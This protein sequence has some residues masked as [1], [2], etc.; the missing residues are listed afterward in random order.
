MIRSTLHGP[1]YFKGSGLWHDLILPNGG[2][3]DEDKFHTY[4]V[5]WSPG[6]I[7]FYAGDPANTFFVEEASEISNGGEWVFDGAFYLFMNLA[8][9]GYWPE[10]ADATTPNPAGVLVGYVRVHKVPVV[11]A[12]SI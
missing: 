8:V 10:D 7:Q 4:G 6:M 9:G 11:P 5:I 2:R 1:N 3:V 12:P